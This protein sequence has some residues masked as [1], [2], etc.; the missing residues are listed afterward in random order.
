VSFFWSSHLRSLPIV[1][2]I[3]RTVKMQKRA[4]VATATKPQQKIWNILLELRSKGRCG[5]TEVASQKR[6]IESDRQVS[7][8][9]L[10][11]ERGSV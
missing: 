9:K 3:L 1:L 10:S 5:K 8:R 4:S 2:P 6:F 7:K 11:Q